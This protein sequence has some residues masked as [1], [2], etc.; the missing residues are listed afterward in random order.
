MMDLHGIAGSVGAERGGS[1]PLPRTGSGA[2]PG[3]ISGEKKQGR[4][5]PQTGGAKA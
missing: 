5:V 3:G 2:S 4:R 1:A